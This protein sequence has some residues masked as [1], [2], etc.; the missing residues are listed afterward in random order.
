MGSVTMGAVGITAAIETVGLTKM[1]GS[2]RGIEQLD[3]RVEPGEIFGFLGPNG[4]GKTTTIRSLLGLCRPTA[5]TALVLGLDAQTDSVTVHRR[6]GYLPGD[7]ALFGR[8]TAR[9]HFNWFA[10]ARGLDATGM[11]NELSERLSLSLDTRAKDMSTGNRQKVGVVLAFM[12]EPELLI[13]DEPTSGLDPLV[14][15]EFEQLLR[16]T[17]AAGRTVFLSSHELD[18]VQRVADRVG[19]IK[20]GRLVLT[21]T[22]AGL[23]K[24]APQTIEVVFRLPVD[25]RRF[26]IDGARVVSSQGP[27]VVLEITGAIAPVLRIIADLDPV[28]LVSRHAEL[29]ELFLDYYRNDTVMTASDVD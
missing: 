18:E 25:P 5:G 20:K 6:V 27:H 10:R 1:F 16:E 13:L 9:E 19:I 17:T 12:H 8:L 21:D 11:A 26:Q 14:K 15:H 28:E 22:V 3:F 29:D 23:R 24:R 4:A 2:V 7:L